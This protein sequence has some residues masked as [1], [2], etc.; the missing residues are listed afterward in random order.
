MAESRELSL[1]ECQALLRSHEAGR[2]AVST[3][4]GPQVIPVNYSLVDEAVIIRTTPYSLLGT[5][6]RDAVLAFEIDGFDRGRRRGWSVLARG[7]GEVVE[8]HAELAHLRE[9]PKSRP[10]AGGDRSLHLRLRWTELTGRLL[11]GDWDPL[12]ESPDDS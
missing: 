4:T 7:R 9:L 5:Y 2:V 8:D 6:G 11:G 12:G 3:P 1:G 10:W